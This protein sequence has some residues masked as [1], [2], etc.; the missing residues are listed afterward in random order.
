MFMKGTIHPRVK[1]GSLWLAWE[2]LYCVG[3]QELGVIC[4]GQSGV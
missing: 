1:E 4:Y 2:D 3:I